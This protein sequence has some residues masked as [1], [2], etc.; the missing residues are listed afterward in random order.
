MV[1]RMLGSYTKTSSS[2]RNHKQW[3]YTL[4]SSTSNSSFSFSWTELKCT[5]HSSTKVQHATRT[6][7]QQLH[8]ITNCAINQNKLQ[9]EADPI[10]A[11]DVFNSADYSQPTPL[12]N[13]LPF[14]SPPKLFSPPSCSRISNWEKWQNLCTKHAGLQ[15]SNWLATIEAKHKF[16]APRV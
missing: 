8:W 10:S 4:L 14:G 12:L 7:W 16:L 6:R 5:C 9:K 13:V 15:D 11:C 3:P 2:T 1:N